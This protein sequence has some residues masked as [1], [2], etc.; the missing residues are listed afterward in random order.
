MGSNHRI[1]LVAS[2]AVAAASVLTGCA[3]GSQA[4]F[5]AGPCENGRPGINV[6]F[7]GP[8]IHG[9]SPELSVTV[10]SAQESY[11][12]YFYNVRVNDAGVAS[13]ALPYPA[14]SANGPGAIDYYYGGPG[15]C[16]TVG[17]ADFQADISACVPVTMTTST[18]C[19]SDAGPSAAAQ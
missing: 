14:G 3:G 17:S 10:S 19:P 18:Q 12:T 6:T 13:V 11:W 8:F 15:V 7:E 5:D 4:A 1:Y 16:N 2:A 9:T